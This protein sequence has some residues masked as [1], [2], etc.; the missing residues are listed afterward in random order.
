M[1]AVMFAEL[2]KKNKRLNYVGRKHL[3]P[4]ETKRIQ[5]SCGHTVQNMSDMN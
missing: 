4:L 1:E 2:K 5:H 3:K